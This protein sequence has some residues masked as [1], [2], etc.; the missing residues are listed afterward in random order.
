MKI[1]DI[2]Y[3][4]KYEIGRAYGGPEEGGWWYDYGLFEGC[5][6][7]FTTRK[8]ARE[9]ADALTLVEGLQPDLNSVNTDYIVKF[10][11]EEESGA[12]WPGE[13]PRYE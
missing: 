1:E 13:V 9:F 2:F 5:E 4:N 7:M 10:F 8:E 11:V 3:V 12:H 6:G